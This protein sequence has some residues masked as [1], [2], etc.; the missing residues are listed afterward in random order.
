MVREPWVLVLVALV[1]RILIMFLVLVIVV[2]DDTYKK[3]RV[4]PSQDIVPWP[5]GAPRLGLAV[6][7]GAVLP[8][9]QS[10]IRIMT[11]HWAIDL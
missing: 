6:Y 10:F 11:Y 5:C 9:R 2:H 8:R 7:T 4:A 3:M 1:L